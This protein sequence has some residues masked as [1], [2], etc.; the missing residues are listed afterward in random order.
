M[1]EDGIV[2]QMLIEQNVSYF[3]PLECMNGVCM[4]ECMYVCM[5]VRTV[6]MYCM[7]VLY[8]FMNGWMNDSIIFTIKY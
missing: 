6:C 3:K 7:Y 1:N 2:L 5:Y 4:Y 8:V